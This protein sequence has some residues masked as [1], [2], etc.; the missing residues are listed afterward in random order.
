[1]CACPAIG[2]SNLRARGGLVRDPPRFGQRVLSPLGSPAL[3]VLSEASPVRPRRINAPFIGNNR[4]RNSPAGSR[5][6]ASATREP[7]REAN[8]EE[9][10]NCLACGGGPASATA[11][12]GPER[13]CRERRGPSAGDGLGNRG[14]IHGRLPCT[15]REHGGTRAVS[16][17]S[18]SPREAW[19]E[20]PKVVL[21]QAEA[22]AANLEGCRGDVDRHIRV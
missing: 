13:H 6:S 3:R 11:P 16:R 18:G 19:S 15:D 21:T 14:A 8:P 2:L 5:A 17:R 10:G 9:G 12:A 4:L 22:H 20:G 7:A 1:M